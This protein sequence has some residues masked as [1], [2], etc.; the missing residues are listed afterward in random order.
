[1]TENL[2]FFEKFCLDLRA[3]QD[4]KRDAFRNYEVND[5]I[6]SIQDQFVISNYITYELG[7][8]ELKRSHL[9]TGKRYLIWTPLVAA[10]LR[11]YR[12]MPLNNAIAELN[13]AISR[14]QAQIHLTYAEYNKTMDILAEQSE[15]YTVDN[16]PHYV[17]VCYNKSVEA[18]DR[19]EKK[20]RRL[21]TMLIDLLNQKI[22]LLNQLWS[23]ADHFR[24]KT[25]QRVR[26]YYE[27][28]SSREPRLPVQYFGDERF[29]MIGNMS[30]INP[31]RV[32]ELYDT[33][34]LLET[35]ME[36]IDDLFP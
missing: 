2:N 10:R 26:Y 22:R 8:Y 14:V 6:T 7:C 9:H 32:R 35:V 1:M 27:R 29:S 34:T 23:F 11:R 25:F 16:A 18:R 36:E 30:T 33:Q 4:V 13:S 21:Y 5:P 3:G 12:L 17:R 28:A 15:Q 19:F 20:T 24:G 31:A